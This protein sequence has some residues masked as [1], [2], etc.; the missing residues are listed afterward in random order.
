[1]TRLQHERQLRGWTQTDLGYHARVQPSDISRIETGRMR[2]YPNQLARL[3]TALNLSPNALLDPIEDAA[4][5]RQ[6]TT[7]A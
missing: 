6:G 1:M 4:H 5:E 7:A 2:P 3:A